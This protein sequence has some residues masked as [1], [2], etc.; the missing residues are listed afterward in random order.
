MWGIIAAAAAATLWHAMTEHHLHL[1][2]L[3]HFRPGTVVPQTTHDTWWH[4]LPKSRQRTVQAALT[5]AGLAGGIAYETAPRVAIV[6]LGGIVLA[7]IMLLAVRAAG[8]TR[9]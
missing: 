6:V 5:M 4:G 8:N 7:G 1:R 2:L 3:R 9:H